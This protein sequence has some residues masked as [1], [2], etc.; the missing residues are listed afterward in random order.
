M[1]CAWKVT[2]FSMDIFLFKLKFWEIKRKFLAGLNISGTVPLQQLCRYCTYLLYIL[3]WSQTLIRLIDYSGQSTKAF[4]YAI[5]LLSASVIM[6]L[7]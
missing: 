6:C 2:V 7:V 3:R 5:Y 4:A 1:S